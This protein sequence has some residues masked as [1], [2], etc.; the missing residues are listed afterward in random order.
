MIFVKK[1]LQSLIFMFGFGSIFGLFSLFVEG[2]GFSQGTPGWL[3]VIFFLFGFC[4]GI[5]ASAVFQARKKGEKMWLSILGMF[6]FVIFSTIIGFANGAGL[7]GNGIL[8]IEWGGLQ[9]YES[10]GLLFGIFSSTIGTYLSYRVL[11]EKGLSA[12]RTAAMCLIGMGLALLLSYYAI[13]I[14]PLLLFL[15]LLLTLGFDWQLRRQG[16]R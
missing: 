1:L 14:G 9:G 13:N 2:F 7:G 4:L 11:E 10:A 16:G 12:F 15:P 3:M 8:A 6:S 5:W